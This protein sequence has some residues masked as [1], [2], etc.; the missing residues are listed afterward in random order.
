MNNTGGTPITQL[1]NDLITK[2]YESE[3]S[4]DIINHSDEQNF[5]ILVDELNEEISAN[6]RQQIQEKNKKYGYSET[7][8]DTEVEIKQEK[9]IKKAKKSEIPNFLKDPILILIIYIVLSQDFSVDFFAKYIKFIKP[10][11]SGS[12]PFVGVTIYGIIFALI[13]MVCKLIINKLSH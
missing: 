13:F 12:I 11:E 8:T 3:K 6:K 2:K 7:D 9:T 10:N 5:D 4:Q 1:R